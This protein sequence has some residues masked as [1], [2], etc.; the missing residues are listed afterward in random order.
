MYYHKIVAVAMLTLPL[1]VAAVEQGNDFCT[2]YHQL[3]LRSGKIECLEVIG[4]PYNE[5]FH[6]QS[7]D[8]QEKYRFTLDKDKFIELYLTFSLDGKLHN[9]A[10]AG[11]YCPRAS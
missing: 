5:R 2:I 1:Q 8:N 4:A 6:I 9:K 3:E 11:V 10:I 7:Y